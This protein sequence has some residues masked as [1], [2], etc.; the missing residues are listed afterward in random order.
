[1]DN[2]PI[3]YLDFASTK[4]GLGG[5]MGIDATDKTGS[6]TSREW[7]KEIKMSDDVVR[8]IDNIWSKLGLS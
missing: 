7:G 5:K 2:T 3:D 6:E 1:M 4:D 8:K